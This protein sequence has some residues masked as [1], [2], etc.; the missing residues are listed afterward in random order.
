MLALV[1]LLT[2]LV[3]QDP[4]PG[5]SVDWVELMR[6]FQAD[7]AALAKS[8]A[9]LDLAA[10]KVEKLAPGELA[11]EIGKRETAFFGEGW[12]ELLWMLGTAC[13][14]QVEATA[15]AFQVTFQRATSGAL[16]AWYVPARKSI[17]IDESQYTSD[18][19][20][21]HVLL[22][23]LALAGLDQQPGGLAALRTGTSTDELLC[24]RAWIEGRAELC[25]RRA[26]GMDMR[27]S[28]AAFEERTGLFDLIDLAGQAEVGRQELLPAAQRSRPQSGTALL[29]GR[30]SAAPPPFALDGLEPAGTKLLRADVLGELGL[31]FVLSLAGAHPARSIEAG[32]GLRADRLRLW[33]YGD[34]DR[35]FAWRLVFDR[36]SDAAELEQLFGKL[37][38]GTRARHAY[39]LDWCF[40]TRP[41][42]EAELAQAL[43][44]LPLPPAASE[45]EARATAELQEA[46]MALQPHMQGERWLLPELDLA[47]KLPAGW[48][49]SYYQASAIVYLG[50]PDENFRDNLTF[51]EYPLPPDATPEKVLEGVRESFA[52]LAGAKLVRAELAETPAGRGVRVEFTQE[53]SG[54]KLHQLELQLVLPGRKQAITATTLERHWQDAGAGIEALLSA[55]ER[56]ARPATPEP[57]K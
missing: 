51:R 33:K 30:T 14:L 44:A 45:V 21:D 13:G 9:P 27:G 16:P 3:P 49:P 52:G 36:E 10:L 41:D 54:R 17:V 37:A 38:R 23:A 26:L 46:R 29:H 11:R 42:L 48:K 55:T 39:V 8:G 1:A 35:A 24:A 19:L 53:S 47:W 34:R 32:I 15:D 12:Y 43:A 2:F 57:K 7:A 4:Q 5:S 40:A 25:A 56:S 22:H 6:R 50:A 20:F 28:L 31:R 18:V